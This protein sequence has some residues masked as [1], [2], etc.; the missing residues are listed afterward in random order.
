MTDRFEELTRRK[1]E[2]LKEL[3]RRQGFPRQRKRFDREE[4]ERRFQDYVESECEKRDLLCQDIERECDELYERKV[5]QLKRERDALFEREC[6]KI[7]SQYEEL[8][9]REYK[10]IER[11][12]EQR[13]RREALA[14]DEGPQTLVQ[15]LAACHALNLKFEKGACRSLITQKEEL[16]WTFPRRIVPWEGF[17]KLQEGIWHR[18][19]S[20]SDDYFCKGCTFSSPQRLENVKRTLTPVNSEASLQHFGRYAVENV[21]QEMLDRLYEDDC[22]WN[23]IGLGDDEKVSIETDKDLGQVYEPRLESSWHKDASEPKLSMRNSHREAKRAG[24][25]ANRSCIY[26]QAED[27]KTPV[28]AMVHQ[29]P[30]RLQLDEIDCGLE[31]EIQLE[32]DVIDQEGTDFSFA[33]KTL[34]AATITQLFSYM[35]GKGIRFGCVSTG[36]AFIFCFIPKDDPS[37]IYCRACVPERDVQP[38]DP[39]RLHRTA[40]ALVF[41]IV[42]QALR[43]KPPPEPWT[44]AVTHL[45]TWT[46]GYDVVLD[47]IR[48]VGVTK[49]PALPLAVDRWRGFRRSPLLDKALRVEV[50]AGSDIRRWLDS[51]A[52]EEEAPE[53]TS[54]STVRVPTIQDQPFCSQKCLLGL[55]H[56]TA[57]DENCPNVEHHGSTH[58]NYDDFLSHLRI[59]LAEDDG[60][61]AADCTPVRI[62][63]IPTSLFKIRLASLGYT[64]IAKGGRGSAYLWS[65]KFVYDQVVSLQGHHVP[66]CIGMMELIEPRHHNRKSF[67]DLLLLSWVGRPF[68]NCLK[69]VGKDQIAG[70]IKTG[71]QAMH[72][73]GVVYNGGLSPHN[74]LYDASRG[75]AMIVDFE[76]SSLEFCE[77]PAVIGDY[78]TRKRKRDRWQEDARQVFQEDTRSA[79]ATIMESAPRDSE[80]RF[81]DSESEIGDD[82]V[83]HR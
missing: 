26:R 36:E 46:M 60:L 67:K 38:D 47:K 75:S 33:S 10:K 63:N 7:D 43:A 35:V 61:E 16:S 62:A 55:V 82:S 20:G 24:I 73:L 31:S 48:K 30:H 44:E 40:A 65:E 57:L 6:H 22:L 17:P 1:K 53:D 2:L 34:V 4:D 5:Q 27:E 8:F 39:L 71:L 29:L 23:I 54:E 41:G 74:F 11:Q 9:D 58:L 68:Q 45:D 72:K 78:Q 19:S 77:T 25:W 79:L 18:L 59:Q 66:V 49:P 3:H 13:A 32:R 28:F 21:I 64:L 56:G 15:Y 80:C 69:Q 70:M 14:K 37:T 51:V 52:G 83:S 12:I 81:S 42:L 76:D 50:K